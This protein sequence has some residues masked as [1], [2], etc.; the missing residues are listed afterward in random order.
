MPAGRGSKAA[1]SD[2]EDAATAI[3][4][5]ETSDADPAVTRPLAPARLAEPGRR[6]RRWRIALVV[7]ALLVLLGLAG[8]AAAVAY[9]NDDRADR[10]QARAI[11][12][13]RNAAELNVLLVERSKTLNQ[14]TRDLN[15]SSRAIRDARGAL[16]RSES[17]VASLAARQRELANEKAQVEDEREQIEVQA[18]ALVSVASSYITCKNGLVDLVG[19]VARDDWNWVDYYYDGISYDCDSAEES[20]DSYLYSYGGE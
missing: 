3:G 15:A 13:E 16:R 17:D 9:L 19:A 20:L 8:A 7:F 5:P 18:S 11:L 2:A 10:W 12:L 6:G 1:S 4:D 14:R